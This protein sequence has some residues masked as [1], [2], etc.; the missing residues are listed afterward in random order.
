MKKQVV[1]K[2]I[3]PQN[4]IILQI[5]S[6]AMGIWGVFVFFSAIYFIYS[7]FCCRGTNYW[8][9]PLAFIFILVG[10]YLIYTAYLMLRDYT[11][12]AIRHFR[13]SIS[14]CF[15]G[16][17]I[18]YIIMRIIFIEEAFPP[19]AVFLPALLLAIPLYIIVKTLTKRLISDKINS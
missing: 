13:S 7:Y 5:L 2:N 15:S 10:T 12:R 6:V 4:R 8:I 19:A 9:F 16:V 11:G 1:E 14:F 18:W 17:L 3:G